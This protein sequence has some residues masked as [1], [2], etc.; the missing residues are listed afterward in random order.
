MATQKTKANDKNQNRVGV[1]EAIT[2]PLGFFVLALLIVET[3][4]G[5][6]LIFANLNEGNKIVG[7]WAG[8]GM[9]CLVT[10]AVVLLDWFKPQNLT[11]DKQAHLIDRGKIPYGASGQEVKPEKLFN[12]KEKESEK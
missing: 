11:Y 4:L 3:F 9:F 10:I 5:N 8:I 7:M 6:V 12:P 1:V 2:T